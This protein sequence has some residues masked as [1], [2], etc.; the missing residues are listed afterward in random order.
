[1]ENIITA[2]EKY[3]YDLP[4]SHT[5]EFNAEENRQRRAFEAGVEFAQHWYS[6]NEELPE[7]NAGDIIDVLVKNDTSPFP[8]RP[9]IFTICSRD[10]IQNLKI[11]F[12]HWRPI[13]LK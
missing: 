4:V 13:N 12:T 8:Q 1:M 11:M 3:I 10:Y 5:C 6:V 2:R 7:W 9:R